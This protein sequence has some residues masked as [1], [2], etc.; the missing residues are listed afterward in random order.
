[1][2]NI[3]YDTV[4]S[5]GI[6]TVRCNCLF[7]HCVKSIWIKLVS[8]PVGKL[9]TTTM[10]WEAVPQGESSSVGRNFVF[11]KEQ[12]SLRPLTA[13]TYFIYINLNLTCT[14]KCNA[15]L[16]T[17]YVGNKITCNVQLPELADSTPVYG[18]CWTVSRIEN[19][20]LISK[21]NVPKELNN[22]KLELTGSGFGMFLVD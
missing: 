7:L 17:V 3:E 8:P 9:E 14:H 4:Q 13:G 18:Q 5:W 16:L 19:E 6:T 1:M 10:H 20:K 21:M 12:Q 15:G 11:D 22:W 2:T